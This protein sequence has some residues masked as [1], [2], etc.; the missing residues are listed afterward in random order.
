MRYVAV[1]AKQIQICFILHYH[2]LLLYQR[3][4]NLAPPPPPHPQLVHACADQIIARGYG[5]GDSGGYVDG[6]SRM[7]HDGKLK[8]P[9]AEA[10]KPAVEP[11]RYGVAGG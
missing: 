2:L 9:I 6:G 1:T 11:A 4:G 5:D 10:G 7:E 3:M 8:P